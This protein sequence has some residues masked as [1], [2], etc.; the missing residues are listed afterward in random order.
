MEQGQGREQYRGHGPQ[1]HMAMYAVGN[2]PQM[3]PTGLEIQNT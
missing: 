1:E 2:V 3:H